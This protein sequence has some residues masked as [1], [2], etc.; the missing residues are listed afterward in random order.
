MI[1]KT[2]KASGGDDAEDVYTFSWFGNQLSWAHWRSRS[3]FKQPWG[4]SGLASSTIELTKDSYAF[5]SW[6]EAF[7]TGKEVK[8]SVVQLS[9]L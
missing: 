9:D 7:Q 1:L 2:F 6:Q 4:N 8:S 3:R 5:V